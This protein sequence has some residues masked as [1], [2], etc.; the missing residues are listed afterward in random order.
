MRQIV[1]D[2]I[3]FIKSSSIGPS[4]RGAE[5][6]MDTRDLRELCLKLLAWWG[7]AKLLQS[8][9]PELA[10]SMEYPWCQRLARM[11]QVT[12]ELQ[13]LVELTDR[14][15]RFAAPVSREEWQRINDFVKENY[16]PPSAV[17]M[18]STSASQMAPPAKE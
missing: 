5:S 4:L 14:A 2:T 10:F 15:C 12:P 7:R 3:E 13:D 18:L 17:E 16:Q 8:D 11:I 1:R 9:H 6:I